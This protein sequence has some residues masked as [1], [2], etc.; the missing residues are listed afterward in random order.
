MTTP[1]FY[2]LLLLE[3]IA[4]NSR[5]KSKDPYSKNYVTAKDNVSS[6]KLVRD[7]KLIQESIRGDKGHATI[8]CVALKELYPEHSEGAA[9][10]L[11]RQP[12]ERCFALLSMTEPTTRCPCEPCPEPCPERSEGAAR[13]LHD[14]VAAPPGWGCI[15]SLFLKNNLGLYQKVI[16]CL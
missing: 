14:R 1:E 7:T 16:L 4:Y 3:S 8:F 10:N 11:H 13:N 2:C 5:D 15:K 9:R 12:A 6:N